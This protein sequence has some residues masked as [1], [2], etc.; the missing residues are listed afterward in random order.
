[1]KRGYIRVDKPGPSPNEQRKALE[2]AGV[3]DFGEFGHVYLDG[4]TTRKKR[5]KP[6]DDPLP[7]RTLAVRSLRAGDVLVVANAGRLGTSREDILRAFAAVGAKGASVLDAA[8]GQE[9]SCPADVAGA[10]AFADLGHQKLMME[11][12][13][14]ARRSQARLNAKS[15][16]KPK[17]SPAEMEMLRQMWRNPNVQAQ[18]ILTNAGVKRSTLYRLFGPRGTPVFGSAEAQAT[19][20][21]SRKRKR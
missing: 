21:K 13:R 3:E 16:P 9:F 11:R 17:I 5:L 6:G 19:M 8:E 20:I 15:G 1:M 4:L 12:S 10:V 2:A 14:H 7:G 18:D